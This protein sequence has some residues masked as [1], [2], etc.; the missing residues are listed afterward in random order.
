MEM[1]NE[2]EIK[3]ELEYGNELEVKGDIEQK[4]EAEVG[5][6]LE[7]QANFGPAYDNTGYVNNENA[8]VNNLLEKPDILSGDTNNY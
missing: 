2:L 8:D 6:E 5:G 4:G 7:A 3:G 1:N